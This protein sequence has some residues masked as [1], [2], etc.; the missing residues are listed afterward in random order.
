MKKD[1]KLQLLNKHRYSSMLGLQSERPL[2]DLEN[3]K[4]EYEELLPELKISYDKY[5]KG[6]EFVNS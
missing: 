1:K 2:D 4:K 5:N 6:L 3:E